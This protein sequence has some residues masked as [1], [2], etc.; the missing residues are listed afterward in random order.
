MVAIP[1][2]PDPKPL[3]PAIL[4]AYGMARYVY[5]D[6][7]TIPNQ[8]PEALD[9]YR[10]LVKPPSQYK[11][12]E[13]IQKWLDENQDQAA[14]DLLAKTSLDGGAGHVCTIGWAKNGGVIR[15]EHAETVG[16][17]TEILTAFFS[18]LEPYHSEILVGHNIARFDI[19]FLLKRAV[20][21]GVGLPQPT[22]FP[23]DPKP[24]DSSVFDT[25]VAW[26]GAKDFIG[27][28]ALCGILGIVGK[29]DFDGSQVAEA[30]K[31][32][33]HMKIAQYCDSD[34]RRTRLMHQ[35]FLEAGWP[36]GVIRPAPKDDAPVIDDEIPSFEGAAE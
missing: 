11:K 13:S 32:G 35:K 34:V 15:V 7:E 4:G 24:W 27:M 9:R 16:E 23:R 20:V 10:K 3:S 2:F 31:N 12:P 33:E 1:K 26:A 22:S 18:D 36:E 17:E 14:A 8:S 30:W 6:I 29:E 19:P 28:N 21:L 5:F 25:M